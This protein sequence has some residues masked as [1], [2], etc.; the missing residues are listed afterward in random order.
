MWCGPSQRYP[1]GMR[2]SANWERGMPKA[3]NIGDELADK[4]HGAGVA[5]GA[6]AGGQLVGLAYLRD[7][8][9]DFDEAGGLVAAAD[10][11]NDP[12][13]SETVR[14]LSALGDLFVGMCSCGEFVVL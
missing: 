12:R 13:I 2:V 1:Y 5:L 6:V 7:V 14:E 8:L 11:I 3:F 4:C 9:P 10:A